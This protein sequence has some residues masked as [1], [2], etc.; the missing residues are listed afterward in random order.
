MIIIILLQHVCNCQ[1]STLF[2]TVKRTPTPRACVEFLQEGI[3]KDGY[4]SL[5]DFADRQYTAYCDFTSDP[6]S[7]WTLITSFSRHAV[8]NEQSQVR[9]ISLGL[10][11][12]HENFPLVDNDLGINCDSAKDDSVNLLLFNL[13]L[14]KH[15]HRL[16]PASF[17]Q[18]KCVLFLG[19]WW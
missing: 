14:V 8:R 3:T 7:A 9:Q 18:L 16:A 12:V 6:G 1:L 4:Y 11:N 17:R 15:L 5:Y 10:A 19:A 2:T 13:K